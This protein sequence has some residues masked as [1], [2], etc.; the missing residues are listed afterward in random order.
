[1]KESS[2]VLGEIEMIALDVATKHLPKKD[3]SRVKRKLEERVS[4]FVFKE[5]ERRTLVLP[6]L[7]LV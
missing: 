3:M 4:K 1:M 2:C 5:T 6:T 7:L